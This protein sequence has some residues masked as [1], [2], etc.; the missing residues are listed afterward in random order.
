MRLD[1]IDLA[2]A[3][4]KW[5]SVVNTNSMTCGEFLDLLKNCQLLKKDSASWSRLEAS[6]RLCVLT[7]VTGIYWLEVDRLQIRSRI[8][9]LQHATRMQ[10]ESHSSLVLLQECEYRISPGE[11]CG[12]QQ[13]EAPG[14]TTWPR[15]LQGLGRLPVCTDGDALGELRQIM[16]PD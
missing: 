13:V 11:P 14:V 9:Y 2:G 6:I 4:N 5:Q 10:V 15:I 12:L 1:W 7:R 3:W 8:A 16:G